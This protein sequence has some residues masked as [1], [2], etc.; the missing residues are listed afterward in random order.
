[1]DPITTAIIAAVA[2]GASG[3]VTKK[4]IAES[5]DGLKAL[6]KKRFGGDSDVA[7]AVDMLEE[8]PD[9]KGRR[10]TVEDALVAV[11]AGD[12]PELLAAAQ[13]LLDQIKSQPGGEQHIQHVQG[14]FNAVAD[15]GSSASVIIQGSVSKPK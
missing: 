14:D 8:K 5:Y 13:V 4:T 12:E 7:Q 15:R 1:M 3:E 6:L 10:Q 9:A 11:N 2:A